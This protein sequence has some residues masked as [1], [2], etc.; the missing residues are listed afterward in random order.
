MTLVN[1]RPYR[2]ALMLSATLALGLWMGEA[3]AARSRNPVQAQF[4]ETGATIELARRRRFRLGSR[5]SSYRV[6]GFRRG[7]TCLA[8]GA[9][10][11]PLVPPLATDEAGE[12]N[13]AADLPVDI[14]TAERPVFFVH[15]PE[16]AEPTQA[17]F[18]LQNE[19]ATEELANVVF[20]LS[21]EEGV[22]G[23]QPETLTQ[24][25]IPGDVYY[26]Q[27]AL[28]CDAASP[29]D[30]PVVQGWITL[31]EQS[32]IAEGTVYEQAVT[33]IEEGIWPDA[34]TLLAQ[35]RLNASDTSAAALAA[36]DWQAVM[37]GVGLADFADEPVVDIMRQ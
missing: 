18:T 22:V 5:S 36:E 13:E 20:N 29:D 1:L 3:E 17:Q 28:Q 25:L 31:K 26:W 24:E 4:G 12:S 8:D 35:A 15:V 32:D 34:V 21:G 16:L 9:E 7:G 37:E 14:T 10:V 6:G 27:M 23:L 33:L 30:N 19:N 2:N 11:T